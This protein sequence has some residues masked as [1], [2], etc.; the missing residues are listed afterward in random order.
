MSFFPRARGRAEMSMHFERTE[1]ERM[2]D[3]IRQGWRA[4]AMIRQTLEPHIPAEA[5]LQ[6][7]FLSDISDEARVLVAA[8]KQTLANRAQVSA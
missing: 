1:H 7:E 2:R 5:M 8:L 6:S 3:Q 4:M